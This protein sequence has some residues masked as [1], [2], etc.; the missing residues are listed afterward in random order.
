MRGLK[1]V[2]SLSLIWVMNMS[3]GQ[4]SSC[5]TANPFCTSVG[6]TFPAATS[7]TAEVGPNYGCLFSQPNPAWY[8]LQ[9]DQTGNIDI[10]LTNSAGNDIDFIC[11]GPYPNAG[12][13]C[14]PTNTGVDCSFSGTAN[15]EIVNIPNAQN[16][17]F[18]LLMITNF[19]GTATNIT[20]T[21]SG[22]TGSTDCSIISPSCVMN[23]MTADV[24]SCSSTPFLEFEVGGTVTYTDPPITGQLIIQDC[25]GQQQVFNAPF[26]TSM[27]YSI[28]GLP[29]DGLDCN[30]TAYFTADPACTI[31]DPVT[32]PAPITGF[33]SN[34]ILGAGQVDGTID[35]SNP[36]AGSNLIVEITD[37]VTTVQDV[38]AMPAASPQNWSVTGLDPTVNPYT[39]T[40]YFDNN[41]ACSQSQVIN[42]GCSADGGTTSTS[43]TGNGTNNFVLCENDQLN[44]TTNNDFAFPD[45]A[46]PLG[47]FAYLPALAYL[48]Y[49]CPPTPGVFPGSDPCFFTIID[50][51]NNLFDINDPAS[52]FAIY[53]GAGTF[54][55]NTLYYTPI[56]LY[57]YDPAAGNYILNSNCWDIGTVSSVTYLDPIT[58]V[59]TP[60][61]QTSS[62]AVTLTGG[63]PA[64]NGSNFTASNL[65][66]ANANFTNTTCANNGDIVIGGLLQGDMWSFD[67]IDINGCPHSVSG[68]PF[69]AIPIADAGQDNTECSL[70]YTLAANPSYG[71][72]TWTGTGGAVFGTPNSPTSTVTVPAAGSYT[73]TWTEDNGGG[74]VDSDDVVV[75]FSDVQYTEVT[76]DPTCGNPDGEITLNGNSGIPTYTYSIDGGL[77]SQ[78]SGSFS[79]LSAGTFAIEVTDNINC[80]ATGS[81]T[82]T[83][84][85]GPVINSVNATGISCNAS[86]DGGISINATGATQF[87][88]DN[89][90]NFQP[91]NNFTNLCAGNYDIIVED[92]IGCSAASIA[93]IIEPVALTHATTQVDLSCAGQCIG[94]IN[95]TEAG[96]TG[97]YQY[98]IDNGLNNSPVGLFQ[99]I[100]AGPYTVLVTDANMCTTTS[101]VLITEPTPMTITIGINDATCFGVC[102]GVM[103]SIPAGGTGTYTYA[104]T[105]ASTGGNVPLVSNLCA[106]NYNLSVTDGNGC[107][108]DTAGIVVG[109][110]VAVTIDNIV[111]VDEL[112]G[113]DC[114]G[115]ITVTSA[116]ATQYSIDG[117]NFSASNTFSNLCAGAYTVEVQDNNGCSAQAPAVISGPA[118]V[119][120]LTSLDTIICIGGTAA[121][122]AVAGGGVGG[123]TYAWDNGA[124]ATQGPNVS[125]AASTIYCATA[126][127]A[128]G[129][130]SPQLCVSVNLNP[131]LNVVAL[132]DQSI[133]EGLFADISALA[134]GGDGG[135]YTYSWN[136]GVGLGQFQSVAPAFTT[137]YTVTASDGCETPDVSATV[138][139]TVNTV[140][141]I[142]FTADNLS[143]CYPVNVNFTEQNVPA[144]SSCLWTFGD[145]GADANCSNV[146][147]DFNNPGCWDITLDITTAEGCQSSVT[148][149]NYICVYDYP[150]PEFSFE[151]Q[152]TTVLNPVINFINET[153]DASIYNWTFD[154]GGE[155]GTSNEENP[156]YTFLPNADTFVVC[157]EAITANGCPNTTCHEV[158][159]LEE[160]IVYVPN[161]FTPDGDLRN[162][163]FKPII[164]GIKPMS[165]EFM[166]FNRWG[167]LIYESNFQ[168]EGWDGKYQNL[169][170]QQDV[171]VWKL[172]VQ[173]QTGKEHSFI[174]HVTLIK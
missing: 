28:T 104:W 39:I 107:V 78:A 49:T 87:S 2:F 162:N 80:T 97:P 72:G 12:A 61:C 6:A 152:P 74:C 18:Y 82:L 100:C 26:G 67:V 161:A 159:I 103:N 142:S 8:Y 169:M 9:V 120:L 146:S 94:E 44:I 160:F 38:M 173:D 46:G 128:N 51:T 85:G 92:A 59:A 21:Q 106:G 54:P 135:P 116:S 24:V 95:I 58:E 20:A 79:L 137:S 147:Y 65:L 127:D 113:G 131:P 3:Y 157:L 4:G 99:N 56:T 111:E 105:P 33:S 126:T 150:N 30:I 68:G 155:N 23:T 11:W 84:A 139:I 10:E 122:N 52:I 141:N 76:L 149:P 174:G 129:C 40:Y 117:L 32:A 50:Q 43:M 35:F 48:V 118:P 115:E 91:L 154:L 171:Y 5:A 15:P 53:G 140:P 165:Y 134:N 31:S 153:P 34:C 64:L 73:L 136:Q 102:D 88:V 130:V 62:V 86:C 138:I 66:P 27:N 13:G 55:N 109:A 156:S 14:Y 71:T 125:P 163:Y 22:G 108:L 47:G 101:N 90:V 1:I 112:C 19:S 16:G 145:G 133:C 151:P 96:G 164:S 17:D 41:P 25:Y 77:S 69:V 75:Q 110:P 63:D 123:F 81:I 60:D 89:G 124:G 114:T 93:T 170:S 29:Q 121:L 57:H 143:G 83:N 70:T 166:V 167:E 7:T 148:I 119:T 158:V 168:D 98:S 144:G 172:R 37:G 132:S 42:C 45:D 36:P